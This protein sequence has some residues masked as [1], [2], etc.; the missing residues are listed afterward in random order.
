METN[1]NGTIQAGCKMKKETMLQLG[2]LIFGVIAPMLI[3]SLSFQISILWLMI[4]FALTWDMMGGQMGYNSLGNIAFFGFGMYI[5]AGV[6][7]GL[8]YDLAEYTSPFT[9]INATFT[10]DQYYTGLFLGIIAAAVGC[11]FIALILS[12]FL[13]GLRGPY[14]A[15]GT[16][17]VALAAGELIGAWE[18]IGAGSGI[19]IPVHPGEA[20]EKTQLFYYL[21]LFAMIGTFL[22]VMALWN[23]LG[24]CHECNT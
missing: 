2:I 10:P 5:C 24:T 18:Y 8:Y 13:F 3:P 21:T 17:G 23:P 19:S 6:Q 12:T 7:V 14:F 1:A 22:F 16:L 20:G 15:I 4:L 9:T 11:V